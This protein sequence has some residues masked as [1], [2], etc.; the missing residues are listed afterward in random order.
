MTGLWLALSVA[1]ALA[2]V[3]LVVLGSSRWWRSAGAAF[4]LAGAA[5]T[6]YEVIDLVYDQYDVSHGTTGD[7]AAGAL[8]VAALAILAG[9]VL[10]LV[11]LGRAGRRRFLVV[12]ATGILAIGVYEFWSSNW[13]ARMGDPATHCSD[14]GH[15]FR[16]GLDRVERMPPGVRCAD[17]GAEILV[18]PDALSWVALVGWSV[19]YAFLAS[20]PLMALAWV[21]RRRPVLRPA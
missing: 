14:R 16:P 15:D 7:L 6:V 17:G 3:V 13:V 10:T 8:T 4:L 5:L 1:I 18:A 19:Y 20:F 2:G 9:M 21:V 11:A 12:F